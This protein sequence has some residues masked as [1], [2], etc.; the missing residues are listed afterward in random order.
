MKQFIKNNLKTTTQ[1]NKTE[2]EQ[3]LPMSSAVQCKFHRINISTVLLNIL[4]GKCL[5][6][7]KLRTVPFLLQ[8][9][10]RHCASCPYFISEVLR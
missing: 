5:V 1:T 4:A 7:E 8:Q 3:D 6:P 9:S 10:V 2:E